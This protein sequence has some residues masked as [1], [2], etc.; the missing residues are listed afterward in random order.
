[1]MQQLLLPALQHLKPAQTPCLLGKPLAGLDELTSHPY[2][3][4]ALEIGLLA[5]S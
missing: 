5:A 1:M 4:P 3:K 2:P